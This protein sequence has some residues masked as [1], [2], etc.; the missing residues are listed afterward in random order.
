M[1]P[2]RVYAHSPASSPRPVLDP[3]ART[4]RELGTK[5]EFDC[6]STGSRPRSFDPEALDGGR[7]RG[8]SLEVRP[9]RGVLRKQ[10]IWRRGRDSNSR[11]TQMD[12]GFQD[13]WFQPLTHP[14]RNGI[15]YLAPASGLPSFSCKHHVNIFSKTSLMVRS[16]R[17]V[18][19]P[20]IPGVA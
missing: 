4:R 16:V 10:I 17:L 18:Y 6:G 2:L 3:E 5:A 20:R 8:G 15:N 11:S 14:S 12:A 13:R 9:S 7:S 1:K 19:R